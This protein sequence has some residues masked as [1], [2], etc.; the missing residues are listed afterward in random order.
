MTTPSPLAPLWAPDSARRLSTRL[1]A[2]TRYTESQHGPVATYSDLHVWS[3]REKAGFWSSIWDFFAL[4][5]DKGAAPYL[6]NPDQMSG[7]RWFPQARLNFAENLLERGE[8]HHV[9]LIERGED[10]GRRE[11]TY[12]DLRDQTARLAQTLR[13]LGVSKG[14]RVAAFLPNCA[15][16]VVTML[17]TASLG[18]VY[19]SCSPDF[20][21]QGVIDRFGQIAP[22]VLVATTGYQYNGKRIDTRERVQ[23]IQTALAPN[24]PH[25]ITVDYLNRLNSQAAADSSGQIADPAATAR[26]LIEARTW[27][28]IQQGEAPP[29]AYVA[30]R[31]EDPLY[32]LYSSGTTGVPKCI[33]HSVGG[34]LL[35]HVKELGLHTDLKSRDRLFFYTTCGWMM[36]NWLVSALALDV[37]VVLYDGSPFHP[38]PDS[39]FNL[40]DQERITAFGAGAKFYAACEKAGLTPRTQHSLTALQAILS[41]GSPLSHESFDYIYRDVKPDVLLAS[42][43]GGTDI[44]SCFALGNPQLPVWQGELQC[45]G[46]GMD[47]AFYDEGGSPLQTGKGELVCQSPF[48]SMPIGFWNDPDGSKFYNAYFSRFPNRWAHGDYGEFIP[49]GTGQPGNG[50]Q[51]III[52]GRSD[53]VLNPG[54]VRI[55][56]AEI[57]RQVEKIPA[58]LESLAI[59]QRQGSDERI[60]L[61]VKLRDGQNLDDS[62]RQLIRATIRD[63]ATPRHVPEVI[64][65]VADLPRTLS[66][67]LVELAVRQVVHGEPVKNQSALANPEALKLFAQLPELQI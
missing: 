32:I 48:P 59:G 3:I 40:A 24:A 67:K 18:A 57:Y 31:F 58:V 60:V 35:Q 61:F 52:H 25:L 39:L 1:H 27:T 23:S 10:G 22:K 4:R 11:F 46:L 43:S 41:T 47:V 63:N 2:F 28:S 45:A 66:G 36:W 44:V 49:H 65:Q 16:S 55:G 42:I 15:E 12:Q 56:T 5:G 37:T 17:A 62:L 33:V 21:L 13:A 8:S 6:L 38:T 51:G 64:C 30:C 50:Q 26:T 20:G 9:A 29:L 19:S 34:T 54:G 7:A 14:D 53:A